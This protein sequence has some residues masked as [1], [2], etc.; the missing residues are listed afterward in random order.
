M[1]TDMTDLSVTDM[2]MRLRR[3]TSAR[4]GLG[5]AGQS[6]ST[7]DML[8][9]QADHARARDAVHKQMDVS[10]LRAALGDGPIVQSS[11]NNRTE[12]LQRPDKGRRLPPEKQNLP[13][14]HYDLLIVIGDGLSATAVEYHAV[15]VVR[16]LQ[17]GLTG[18]KLAPIVIAK[19]ARVALGDHIAVEMGARAVLMLIGERPGLSASDS[20]GAY[21][22]LSPSLDS[23]DSDRNCVSNIRAPNGLPPQEAAGKIQ[24]LY[25]EA[26]RLGATGVALKDRSD[27]AALFSDQ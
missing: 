3:L 22:T 21:L 5:R 24:W 16:A 10:L 1:A 26:L 2:Y 13:T 18:V 15:A 9:F 17:H 12:Y 7:K 4:I 25:Q 19:Q 8:E 20:L 6:V 11:A 27:M 14:G 23:R